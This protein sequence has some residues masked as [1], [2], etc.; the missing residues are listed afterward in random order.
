M[1]RTVGISTVTRL[2]T[3]KTDLVL[4]QDDITTLIEALTYALD[5]LD[6]DNMTAINT[7]SEIIKILEGGSV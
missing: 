5:G 7:L 2:M 1:Y 4:E 3:P 6:M